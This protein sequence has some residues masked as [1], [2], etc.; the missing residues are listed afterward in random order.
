MAAQ[1]A[2]LALETYISLRIHLS[3]A[4]IDEAFDGGS[5]GYTGLTDAYSRVGA[6]ASFNLGINEEA[7]FKVG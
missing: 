1:D 5:T 7:D 4:L 6:R 3:Q 2:N